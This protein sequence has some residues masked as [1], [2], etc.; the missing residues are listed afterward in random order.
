MHVGRVDLG[1]EKMSKSLGNVIWVKDFKDDEFMPYRMLVLSSPYRNS[2]D[3]SAELFDQYKKS[4]EKYTRAYKQGLTILDLANAI[5]DESNKQEL[6][7]FE[8]FMDNDLNTSNAF[9][10]CNEI[11]KKINVSMRNKDLDSLSL[12]INTL[13]TIFDVFG[14]ALD[15]KKLSDSDKELYIAWNEAKANKDFEKADEIRNELISKGIL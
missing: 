11:L 10:L 3:F 1:K 4:Y 7:E 8:K 15:Y 9:T 14:L 12:E 2:I 5:Q 13:K 6:E